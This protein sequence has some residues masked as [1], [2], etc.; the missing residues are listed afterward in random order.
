MSNYKSFRDFNYEITGESGNILDA[1]IKGYV[2][3]YIDNNVLKC[4]SE[5]AIIS[6]AESAVYTLKEFLGIVIDKCSHEYTN[7][8]VGTVHKMKYSINTKDIKIDTYLP[9]DIEDPM[10]LRVSGLLSHMNLFIP[11]TPEIEGFNEDM[12]ELSLVEIENN[13]PKIVELVNKVAGEDASME[14]I[15]DVSRLFGIDHVDFTVPD[16][17][18]KKL[19]MLVVDN[20]TSEISNFSSDNVEIE[21]KVV[22]EGFNF[23]EEQEPIK[24]SHI[25]GYLNIIKELKKSSGF[26]AAYDEKRNYTV[27]EGG[28]FGQIID[29]AVVN[30]LNIEKEFKD[31][32]KAPKLSDA[33]KVIALATT[34]FWDLVDDITLEGV[35]VPDDIKFDITATL[36]IDEYGSVFIKVPEVLES[37]Y[38]FN[39]EVIYS[40][41]EELFERV[42]DCLNCTASEYN[43]DG[44]EN[45]DINMLKI[46][47]AYIGSDFGVPVIDFIEEVRQKIIKTQDEIKS[48]VNL[49]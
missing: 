3:Y 11:L 35:I 12:N 46:L 31:M 37:E 16:F 20:I 2:K 34:V 41:E 32:F 1:I 40:S 48:K 5:S 8:G 19:I 36:T 47:G 22:D 26:A 17:D 30:Y 43:F 45:Y 27:A 49:L 7:L 14:R 9:I 21:E 23:P 15:S 13:I 38:R 29:L 10:D 18:N 44:D 33:L 4:S 6:I 25:V 42:C 28:V 39:D 24:D